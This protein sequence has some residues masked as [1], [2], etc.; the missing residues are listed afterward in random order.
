MHGRPLSPLK[1]PPAHGTAVLPASAPA[2]AAGAPGRGAAAELIGRSGGA[3]RHC[4]AP[5]CPPAAGRHQVSG[6]PQHLEGPQ[7]RGPPTLSRGRGEP[8]SPPNLK[9]I[10]WGLNPV[11]P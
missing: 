3:R 10:C 9:S 2:R 6:L 8:G 5:Y 11:A 7:S 4:S 1:S